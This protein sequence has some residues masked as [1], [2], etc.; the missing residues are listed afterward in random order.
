MAEERGLASEYDLIVLGAGPGGYI[1]AIRAAQLG[2]RTAVV[3]RDEV[4]GVCL[5]WGCIPSKALLR[6][7]EVLHLFCDAKTW[8][9]SFDN[10]SFDMGAAIAR[11]R[12]VVDR[13]V[14]G[15]KSLLKKHNIE[16]HRGAGRLSGQGR[17]AI[18]A[19]GQTLQ[20]ANV[21]IATGTRAKDLPDLKVDGETVITS[22][23][24]LEIKEPPAS[25]AI[26]G[27]GAVGVEFAYFYR[28]YGSEVTIIE[29]LP[30]LVPT[31][32]EEVSQHLERAL[33][34]QGIRIKTGS[35][36]EKMAR[37]KVG[38]RLTLSP[39]SEVV[40]CERVL[41]GVGIQPNTEDLGLEEL[42]VATDRGFIKVDDRMAASIP[43][44]YAIGDVTGQMPLAHVASAQ[45][46]LAAEV[47]AGRE[48][49][50]L[51]YSHM[52]RATY[53]QPQIASMGLAEKAAIE[54]GYDVEVGRFPFAA[55]G[56]AV[57]LGL[58]D[59]FVKLVADA[60]QGEILG[61]HLI[62]H[63]VTDMLAELSV[64]RMLEGTALEIGRTVHAHPTLSE[65][66]MEAGL[67][68]FGESLNI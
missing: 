28:A 10:M 32:D 46:V 56:K 4:G 9:V 7:A 61:A 17:V 39:A 62:G 47:I 15:V 34:R 50:P 45:G 20:A 66:V 8:G 13:V 25:I 36:V 33:K 21:I 27:G 60:R 12:Q 51:D 55:N 29:M 64:A 68:V 57:A 24:A 58:G 38:A 37:S 23:E 18:D 65:A 49:A 30:R 42:G 53:C 1:A 43:G 67:G 26:V 31:E 22:R 6:N 40:E 16:L 5:N 41:L 44:T 2:L 54:L 48:P 35:T 3:E 63:D 14:K 19:T 11:S 59:G 52:P